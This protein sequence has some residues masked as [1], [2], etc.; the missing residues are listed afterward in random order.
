MIR[1]WQGEIT[2]LAAGAIV[3]AAASAQLLEGALR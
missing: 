3:S 2:T 1:V